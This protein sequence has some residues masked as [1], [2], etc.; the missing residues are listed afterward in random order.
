VK[1]KEITEMMQRERVVRK[2]QWKI[3]YTTD[4]E[5][6]KILNNEEGRREVKMS[7]SEIRKR[8]RAGKRAARKMKSKMA[9]INAKRKRS[10]AKR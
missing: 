10:M 1:L 9:S 5:G 3:R 7:P 8:K 2:G 4:R 6:Y